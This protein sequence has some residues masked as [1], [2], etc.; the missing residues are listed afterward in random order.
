MATSLPGFL[1]TLNNYE[2]RIPLDQ[3]VKHM[4]ALELSLEDVEHCLRFDPE[5]YSRN[6]LSAGPA[7]QALILCWLPGQESVIHD[8]V[9][10]S[11][12][13]MVLQG[14]C[15]EVFFER[16]ADG[17]LSPR[18][19]Q[20]LP[21][22]AICGA[23]DDNIHKICNHSAD[24]NLVTLHIYSPPLSLMNTYNEAGE[25]LGELLVPLNA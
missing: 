16:R 5:R 15:T 12:G 6:L 25:L 8:H 3:L 4:Q 22:G 11:C 21:P 19:P 2:Q 10:S 17:S 1:A 24:T 23:Q 20:D 13:V 14:T 9:G 18:A 7:Y